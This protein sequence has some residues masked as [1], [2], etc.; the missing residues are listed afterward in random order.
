[1]VAAD[2]HPK[3]EIASCNSIFKLN[4]CTKRIRLA[5]Q[6]F[7]LTDVCLVD[8]LVNASMA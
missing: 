6:I 3:E 7:D 1:M 4:T 5:N 8:K 2:E